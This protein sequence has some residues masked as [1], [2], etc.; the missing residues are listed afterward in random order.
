MTGPHRPGRPAACALALALMIL[1]ADARAED[2]GLHI[3]LLSGFGTWLLH[4]PLPLRGGA[5]HADDDAFAPGPAP[6]VELHLGASPIPLFSFDIALAL[7]WAHHEDEPDLVRHDADLW[8]AARVHPW[9]TDGPFAPFAEV[10]GGINTRSVGRSGC[11]LA[12]REAGAELPNAT[13]PLLV[14]GVGAEWYPAEGGAHV[15]ARIDVL[16]AFPHDAVGADVRL[17][18]TLGAGWR[19]R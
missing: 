18:T 4:D 13:R 8:V 9:T 16:T 15:I 3:Q 19:W 17:A 5:V 14:A 11:V 2:E 1:A 7:R 6:P 12:C 10:G